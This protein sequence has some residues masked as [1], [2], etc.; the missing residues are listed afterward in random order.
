MFEPVE[1]NYTAYIENCQSQFGVKPRMEWPIIFYGGSA[2]DY[3]AHS[4]II[5]S[6]GG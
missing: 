5:F 6:N 4:N 2:S 3:K 1:W